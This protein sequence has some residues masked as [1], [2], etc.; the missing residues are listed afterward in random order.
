MFEP[1]VF[2]G[3]DFASHQRRG[4]PRWALSLRVCSPRIALRGHSRRC[5]CS[6]DTKFRPRTSAQVR[7]RRR[8]SRRRRGVTDAHALI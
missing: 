8:Q 6:S 3:K 1:L 7:Q 4:H 5:G 2:A